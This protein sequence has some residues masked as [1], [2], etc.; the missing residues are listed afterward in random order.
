M[1]F[2]KTGDAWLDLELASSPGHQFKFRKKDYVSAH[3]LA[4]T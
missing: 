2:L 1:E 3:A 4:I